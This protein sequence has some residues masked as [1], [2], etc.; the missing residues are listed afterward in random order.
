MLYASFVARY[1][2]LVFRTLGEPQLYRF[3][4]PVLHQAAPQRSDSLIGHTRA[5]VCGS[6]S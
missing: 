4:W 3:L 2:P 1:E 5:M 6:G